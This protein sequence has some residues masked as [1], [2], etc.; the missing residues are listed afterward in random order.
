MESSAQ[1]PVPSLP[2]RGPISN[3]AIALARTLWDDDH[4]TDLALLERVAAG[5]R[6]ERPGSRPHLQHEIDSVIARYRAQHRHVR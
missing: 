5:L 3:Q 1:E 4:C 2:L 6:A